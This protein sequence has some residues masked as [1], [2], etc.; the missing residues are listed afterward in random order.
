MEPCH[1]GR[2]RSR[3]LHTLLDGTGL[4]TTRN[5]SGGSRPPGDPSRGVEAALEP[6]ISLQ[7]K[8][9]PRAGAFAFLA[10]VRLEFTVP[11]SDP[12]LGV[13]FAVEPEHAINPAV[14]P[15]ELSLPRH[16]VF[17]GHHRKG[18]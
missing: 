5:I 14:I 16:A 17:R 7:M 11:Q 8:R 3:I 9:P 18:R 15:C 1:K 6:S 10:R 4:L 13:F 2:Q 12:C